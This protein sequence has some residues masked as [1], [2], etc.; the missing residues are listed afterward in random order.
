MLLA[1]T[2]M[3]IPYPLDPSGNASISNYTILFDI[4]PLKQMAGIIPSS[5]I[6]VDDSDSAASLM[7][8]PSLAEL[9]NHL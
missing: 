7:P 4:V 5:P 2:V 9:Q 6:N 3:D 1:G 8:P